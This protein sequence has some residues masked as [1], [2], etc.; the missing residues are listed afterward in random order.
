VVVVVVDGLRCRG[1]SFS[2]PCFMS[3]QKSDVVEPAASSSLPTVAAVIRRLVVSAL[4]FSVLGVGLPATTDHRHHHQQQ[5]Q[6]Q[7]QQSPHH[8]QCPPV[9]VS[10]WLRSIRKIH[11]N[12]R[13]TF[14]I[15]R[16]ICPIATLYSLA[17]EF[18]RLTLL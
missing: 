11:Q 8:H 14:C 13:N 5:Q 12:T 3:T 1:G 15:E 9:T 6:Q 17:A 2:L 18:Q 7:Q 16:G 10:K 4:L